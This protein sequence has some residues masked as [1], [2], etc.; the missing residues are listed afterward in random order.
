MN[1]ARHKHS[2][3][4]RKKGYDTVALARRA[5]AYVWSQT[6]TNL[7]VYKCGYCGKY[8]LT[9]MLDSDSRAPGRADGRFVSSPNFSC[10]NDRPMW[11]CNDLELR[12]QLRQERKMKTEAELDAMRP[13]KI[14]FSDEAMQDSEEYRPDQEKY[15]SGKNR[16]AHKKRAAQKVVLCIR[17]QRPIEKL[18]ATN[19]CDR[20]KAS[21]FA[22]EA[23][24]VLKGVK[25]VSR[26]MNNNKWKE[27]P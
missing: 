21:G 3:C 18:D 15:I 5:A 16:Y 9:H 1:D 27:R 22:N 7:K 23:A 4:D 17:C 19:L 10:S 20:C 24:S 13:K 12:K 6:G 11:D 8:H 14:E 2:C 25:M 26:M